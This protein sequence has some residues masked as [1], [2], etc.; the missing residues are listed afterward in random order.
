MG[1]DDPALGLGDIGQFGTDPGVER[2]QLLR[3]FLGVVLIECRVGRVGGGQPLGD[4]GDIDLP[5][6]QALPGVGIGDRLG[7][8]ALRLDR[9]S[10]V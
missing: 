7:L 10:V 2:R 9:K 4:V 3:I 5:V 8:A 6:G 1:G